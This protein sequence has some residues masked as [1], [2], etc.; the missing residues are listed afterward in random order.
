MT[1]RT[2]PL[3][4]N[5]LQLKTLVIL[6]QMARSPGHAMQPNE[7][8][9]IGVGNWPPPHGDHFHIGDAV[10]LGRDATG[11][12]N[13][14]VF[15]ALQRRGL[16]RGATATVAILT[17]EGAGYPTGIDADILHRGHA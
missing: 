15:A 7:K 17:P 1:V 2:N 9:D 5:S 14:A 8:G 4:L 13:P 3:K 10:V 16:I 11:F 6:Q 12:R